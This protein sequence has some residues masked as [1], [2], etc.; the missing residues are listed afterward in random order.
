[1]QAPNPDVEG[2]APGVGLDRSSPES[3]EAS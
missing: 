2:P 3:D 1:V